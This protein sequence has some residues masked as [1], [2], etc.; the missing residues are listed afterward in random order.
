MELSGIPNIVT[1]LLVRYSFQVLAALAVLAAGLLCAR[2]AGRFIERSLKKTPIEAHLQRLMVRAGKGLVILFTIVVALDKF[3]IQ[4]TALVAGI[5]V[6]GIAGGFALQGIL[7]NLAAGVSIMLSRH[8][9]IGDYIEIGNVKGQV[10]S[11]EL[12]MTVLRTLDGA[13]VIVPNRRIVGE[14]IYN[15]TAERRVPLSVEVSYQADLDTAVSAVREVLAAN[16][17]VLKDPS[18]EVGITRLAD[19]G[20]EITLRPW[21]KAEDFWRVHYEIYRAILDRFRER[22]IEIPCPQREVRLLNAPA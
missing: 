18:P 12:S 1:D 22:Q 13:R 4:V 3:G 19:S 10:Q 2:A 11:I 8:F 20:I 16:P 9:R 5:S 21:C 6:A 7:G 15:F 14:I 17:L